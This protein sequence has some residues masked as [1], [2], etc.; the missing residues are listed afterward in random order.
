MAAAFNDREQFDEYPGSLRNAVQGK[1][2]VYSC[3]PHEFNKHG[4]ASGELV[5]GNLAL[6]AHVTGTPSDL[7]TKNRI[8]IY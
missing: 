7:D 8:F 4:K 1:K 5:G 3:A 2:T 6:L